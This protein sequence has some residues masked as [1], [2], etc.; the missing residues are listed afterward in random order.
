MGQLPARTGEA[1]PSYVP[2]LDA[3]G[4]EV[5][6]IRVPDVSVPVGTH[7]GWVPRH[8]E[9]GG[10]GQVLDMMGTSLPFARTASERQARSDPRPSIAERYRDRDDYATRARAAAQALADAGYIVPDDVDLAVDLALQR[11]DVLAPAPVGVSG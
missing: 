9:T 4:N 10:A 5:A 2:A 3:D 1:Y 11:Y 7:T 6:G 8:A